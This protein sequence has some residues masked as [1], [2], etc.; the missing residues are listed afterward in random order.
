MPRLMRAREIANELFGDRSHS[1]RVYRM[2]NRGEL[3]GFRTGSTWYIPREQYE[4]WKSER[5]IG[6]V[7]TE[8]PIGER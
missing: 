7:T 5:G 1:W 6:A 2:L 4:E 8:I 3:P